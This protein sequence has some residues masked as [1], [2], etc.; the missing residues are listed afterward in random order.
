MFRQDRTNPGTRVSQ[1]KGRHDTAK[2]WPGSRVSS[3]LNGGL[4][5][6]G[7]YAGYAGGGSISGWTNQTTVDKF[8][9]PTDARSTLGTG[10]SAATAGPGAM[11]NNGVAGYWAGGS[12]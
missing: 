4:Y 6:P 5:G 8:S 10:L 11:A 7:P 12:T 9:F 3:W 2:G 1:W